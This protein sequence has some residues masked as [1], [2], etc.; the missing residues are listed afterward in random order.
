[1]L[2]TATELWA[3]ATVNVGV[4][5]AVVKEKESFTSPRVYMFLLQHE[6]ASECVRSVMSQRVSAEPCRTV[7]AFWTEDWVLRTP[8]QNGFESN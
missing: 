6:A 2:E 1:M 8:P 3:R 5:Q 4:S 7:P